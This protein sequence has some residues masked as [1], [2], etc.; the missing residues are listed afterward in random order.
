[1]KRKSHACRQKKRAEEKQERFIPY[2]ARPE[3]R[4]KYVDKPNEILTE[5]SIEGS[6]V[7]SS[8]Y[9]ALKLISPGQEVYNL[10]DLVGEKSQFNFTLQKWDGQLSIL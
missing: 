1:M 4:R 9:T 2:K 3:I 7:T 10:K 5:A 6:K 8:A